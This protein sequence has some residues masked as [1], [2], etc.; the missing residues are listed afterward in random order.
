VVGT[1]GS[2]NHFSSRENKPIVV[3]FKNNDN[4][5]IIVG[6]GNGGSKC[7]HFPPQ[8]DLKLTTMSM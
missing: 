5:A 7:H 2:N 3:P 1:Y 8:Y 6:S 4:N